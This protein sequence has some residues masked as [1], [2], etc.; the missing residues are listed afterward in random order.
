MGVT[1]GSPTVSWARA[2]LKREV[3]IKIQVV[4]TPRR[5]IAPRIPP[6]SPQS[7]GADI[8][9]ETPSDPEHRVSGFEKSTSYQWMGPS[10]VSALALRFRDSAPQSALSSASPL[11]RGKDR[12]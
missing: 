11:P 2:F 3:C 7:M 4:A 6:R 8:I 9:P 1:A 12:S 10:G 5:K